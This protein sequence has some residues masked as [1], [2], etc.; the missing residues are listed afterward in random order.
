MDENFV[1]AAGDGLVEIITENL[2]LEQVHVDCVDQTGFTALMRAAQYN[3]LQV[4]K[5]LLTSSCNFNKQNKEGWTALMWAAFRG[6]SDIVGKL[7]N[8][9]LTRVLTYSL[10][11][12]LTYSSLTHSITDELLLSRLCDLNVQGKDG[13]TALM[14]AA[15]CGHKKVVESLLANSSC[16]LNIQDNDG[17]TALIW[18]SSNG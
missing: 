18:A 3:Q 12:L 9:L 1:T 16:D 4:I 7:F 8:Y 15:G 13:A 17:Q 5:L 6:N 11:H 14:W 2:L 10:T